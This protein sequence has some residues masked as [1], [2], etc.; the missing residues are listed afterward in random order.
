MP[1][2]TLA[3]PGAHHGL[4]PRFDPEML[5]ALRA[6]MLRFAR[7]QV[8]D[9]AAAEDLVQDAIESALRGA[10]GFAGRSSLKTWVFSILRYGIID[11]LRVVDRCIPMSDL[12]AED[13]HWEE[14]LEAMFDARGAWRTSARPSAWPGPDEALESSEFWTVFETCL[15]HLPARSGR[16]FMMREFLGLDFDEICAQLDLS[17]NNCHVIL[18]RAR[19]KLRECLERGWVRERGTQS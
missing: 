6:D 16:V 8:R 12:V 3:L 4:P 18:H 14:K 5:A 19:L 2:P 15:D 17:H 10:A 11:H 1:V 7:L 13:E 9:S